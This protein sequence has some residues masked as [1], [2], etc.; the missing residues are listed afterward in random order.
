MSVIK[1]L[2][3]KKVDGELRLVVFRESNIES[4]PLTVTHCTPL[5]QWPLLVKDPTN[6]YSQD[7]LD[8]LMGVYVRD[9]YTRGAS[10][11]QAYY[12]LR[13][14]DQKKYAEAIALNDIMYRKT[15]PHKLGV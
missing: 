10:N 11:W 5:K 2:Y 13:R 14:E 7:L 1:D 4:I 8:A 6:T 15:A 3:I 9:N 12:K